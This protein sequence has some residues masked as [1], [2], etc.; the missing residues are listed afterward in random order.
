MM[1]SYVV[2]TL[3]RLVSFKGCSTSIAYKN[4]I[5]FGKVAQIKTSTLKN[6]EEYFNSQNT[7]FN[8]LIKIYNYVD[9]VNFRLLETG[10]E[11]HS[12]VLGRTAQYNKTLSV[13]RLPGR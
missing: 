13:T 1:L 5:S 4:L 2:C 9:F 11:K 7:H 8:N 6:K 10:L 12:D 3:K